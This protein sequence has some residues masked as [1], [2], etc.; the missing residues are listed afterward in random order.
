MQWLWTSLRD[1][2]INL[3]SLVVVHE[4]EPACQSITDV[5]VPLRPKIVSAF[6]FLPGIARMRVG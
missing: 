6:S 3:E 5:E 1:T 2:V 4:C